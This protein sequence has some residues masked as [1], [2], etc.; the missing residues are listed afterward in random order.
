M[1]SKSQL[2]LYS[3]LKVKKFRQQHNLFLAEGL[4]LCEE[5]LESMYA[6]ER[7]LFCA[8]KLSTQRVEKFLETCRSRSIECI[9]I[10]S[11]QLQKISATVE[12]QGVLGLVQGKRW[13]LQEVM[14]AS[15]VNALV[16]HD[17]K[18]PGNLGNILRSAAWF[19]VDAVFLSHDSV[20]STNPKVVRASMGGLFHVRIAEGLEI[21]KLVQTLKDNGYRM[22]LASTQ[23]RTAVADVQ[24]SEHNGFILGGE[25]ATIPAM[26]RDSVDQQVV[27]PRQGWGDSL[28]VANAAAIILSHLPNR[29]DRNVRS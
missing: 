13:T 14:Q 2:K 21:A 5:V 24:F 8:Q 22:F 10:T 16:L 18:D 12:S 20:D 7:V 9:E 15:P 29:A 25:T 4:R 1:I 28:N 27:I 17:I 3:S 23:G 6:L 19:G 26:V 11:T